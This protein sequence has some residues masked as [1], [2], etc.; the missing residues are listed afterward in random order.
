MRTAKLRGRALGL[1]A[2]R[3]RVGDVSETGPFTG[4][5][6]GRFEFEMRPLPLVQDARRRSVDTALA[7]PT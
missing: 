5:L 4:E 3:L 7:R 6:R 2:D 1:V